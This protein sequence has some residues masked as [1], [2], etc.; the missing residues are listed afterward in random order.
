VKC[1][2]SRECWTTIP[3][4]KTAKYDVSEESKQRENLV[5]TSPDLTEIGWDP[6]NDKAT[7]VPI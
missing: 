2:A 6:R 7:I 3:Q 5:E 4:Y 1:T